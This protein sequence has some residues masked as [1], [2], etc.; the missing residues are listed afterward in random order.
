[1]LFNVSTLVQEGIGA[2]RRYDVKGFLVT[3]GRDQEPISGSAELIRTKWG[4]LVRAQMTL[5]ERETCS[6]CL[7]PLQEELSFDFEEEFLETAD[8][9]GIKPP[10]EVADRDAFKIDER[11]VLDLTE[12]VRQYREASAVMKPLCR[13]DCKGLCSDCGLDRNTDE[14]RCEDGII[15]SRW[16][17]LRS[18][19]SEGKE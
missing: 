13:P 5:E 17:A 3:E 16:A 19:I 18:V 11:Q 2:T 6:R 12:A 9:H 4:V 8:P 7:Q 1:M 15:D 14:C 10:P